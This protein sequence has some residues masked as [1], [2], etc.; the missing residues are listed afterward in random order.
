MRKI[1]KIIT[2]TVLIIFTFSTPAFAVNKTTEVNQLIE[3][4][5]AFD[6]KEVTVQGE[7]IGEP[8]LRGDYC[9]ININD[10]TNAIGIWMK[11]QDAQQITRFGNYKNKGDV[12]CVTGIFSRACAEHGGEAD[13]H[14]NT[15][16][17]VQKGA[18]VQEQIPA[19]KIIIAALLLI[20]V[21]FAL[22]AVSHF[23]I[24]KRGSDS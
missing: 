24:L 9:W 16:L 17:I 8:L 15:M 6:G 13:I 4:A 19:I 5:K 3:S 20:I 1:L 22:L 10:G 14:S 23:K 12:I 7:A 11:S 2:L 18:A 21:L